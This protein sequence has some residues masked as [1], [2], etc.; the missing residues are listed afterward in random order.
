MDKH[1]CRHTDT[2]IN[3]HTHTPKRIQKFKTTKRQ[4][5]NMPAQVQNAKVVT[6]HGVCLWGGGRGGGGKID[7]A[8]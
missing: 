4:M 2:K 6:I 7:M 8:S 1:T 3:T 5:C